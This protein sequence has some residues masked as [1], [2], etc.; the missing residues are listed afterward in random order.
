[1]ASYIL[2]V[3]EV[4][5]P[6]LE[7]APRSAQKRWGFSSADTLT[8][9]PVAVISLSD[10]SESMRSPRMP[11]RLFTPAANVAPTMPTHEAEV[12]AVE[13]PQVNTSETFAEMLM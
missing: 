9:L 5:T 7:P 8:I 11:W 10:T 3:A 2:Y 12:V 13:Q 6:K 4:T 1:M